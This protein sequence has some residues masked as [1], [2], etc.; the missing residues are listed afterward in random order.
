MPS[1]PVLHPEEQITMLNHLTTPNPDLDR[2]IRQTP[3]GMMFWAG[4]ATCGGCKHFGYEAATRNEAG[5]V[6][7]TK[8]YPASCILYRKRTGRHGKPL[9][10][11]TPA[12]KYFAAKQA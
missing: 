7:D 6:V 5:N 10:Q 4:S 11:A 8:R 9:E 2:L 1:L 3:E 12:C